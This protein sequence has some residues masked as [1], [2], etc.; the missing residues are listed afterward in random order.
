MLDI[1]CYIAVNS[2]IILPFPG[3]VPSS[4][5]CL[6][7]T[8]RGGRLHVT[9]SGCHKPAF[10]PNRS[11]S[12]QTARHSI[13]PLYG[14]PCGQFV[15]TYLEKRLNSATM[16]LRDGQKHVLKTSLKDFCSEVPNPFH[17]LMPMMSSMAVNIVVR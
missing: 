5:D 4:K 7:S 9:S 6:T 14:G 10:L 11:G 16:G 2:I 17:W 3:F 8:W 15:S 1:V 13:G 12:A